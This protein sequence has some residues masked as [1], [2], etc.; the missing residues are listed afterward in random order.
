MDQKYIYTTL[1]GMIFIVFS[2]FFLLGK[3]FEEMVFLEYWQQEYILYYNLGL[4]YILLDMS[5]HVTSK[6]Y[7]L[8]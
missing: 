7:F 4:S 5:I 2:F 8:S 3:I 6:K 1:S